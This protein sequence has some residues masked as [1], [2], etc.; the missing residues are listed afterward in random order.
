MPT[1]NALRARIKRVRRSDIPPQP[2][3]LDEI[4][5]PE[6]LQLTLSGDS[7]LVKDSVIGEERIL[8]FTTKANIHH[9]SQALFWVMDGTFKTVS[10]VFYQQYTIHAPIGAVDN[11]K[12]L[13]LI[14][15]LM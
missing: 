9:L 14:Y 2:Q 5:I 13:S 6:S 7:F 11:S 1:L 8:L 15:I 12:I 10:T 3:T 4:N